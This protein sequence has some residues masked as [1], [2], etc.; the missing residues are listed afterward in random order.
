M[1][2]DGGWEYGGDGMDA[3]FYPYTDSPSHKGGG[4]I[5]FITKNLT[6][7]RDRIGKIEQLDHQTPD[8]V[9]IRIEHGEVIGRG[10]KQ[11]TRIAS[12]AWGS[13]HS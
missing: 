8:H 12:S 9:A 2:T 5:V 4:S 6:R 3:P 11:P 7:I 13:G 1:Y 10:P